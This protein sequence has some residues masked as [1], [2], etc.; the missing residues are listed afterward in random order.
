MTS[1]QAQFGALP[2][3]RRDAIGVGVTE[4]QWRMAVNRKLVHRLGFGVYCAV[5][6]DDDRLRLCQVTAAAMLRR[7]DHFA[8]GSSALA[9]HDLP[10]PYFRRW[11]R[12]PVQLGGPKTRAPLNIH[13]S[14]VVPI[15][16]SWGAVTDLIHTAEAIATELPLPQALMVTDAVARRI[17]DT[18]NRFMLASER[19]RTEVRRQLTQNLDLPALRLANPAAESPA[20][21]FY[22]GHMLITGHPE[23]SCGVP[24][25]GA[26][27]DQ[28]FIDLLLEGL[29]IEVDGLVK[30]VQG[31]PRILIAEKKRED[32]LRAVG[33]EFHRPFVEDIYADPGLEMVRLQAKRDQIRQRRSA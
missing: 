31:D 22:R 5:I 23:P 7:T 30:Y 4:W 2:F 29:A 17:A 25:T 1:L 21:S 6:A 16:S 14:K 11:T 18:D 24:A 13:A 15:P 3:T 28:Y 32:D 33:Y 19:C 8:V 20:E 10:N 26:T 27:E 9:I 12:L